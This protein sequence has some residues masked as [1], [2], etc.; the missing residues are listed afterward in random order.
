MAYIKTQPLKQESIIE[1]SN[2]KG[3][4]ECYHVY[5]EYSQVLSIA[6]CED[7]WVKR[8]DILK[9]EVIFYDSKNFS[10]LFI[11]KDNRFDYET[12]I[13]DN[14]TSYISVKR[15]TLLPRKIKKGTILGEAVLIPKVE[16]HFLLLHK[17]M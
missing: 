6:I 3:P 1:V 7:K 5:D 16:S 12:K 8:K 4:G 14:G 17:E 11:P 2:K 13:L 9:T 15:K 10:L